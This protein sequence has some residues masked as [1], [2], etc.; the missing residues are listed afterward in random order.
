MLHLNIM[1]HLNTTLH[2]SIM[3]HRSITLRRSIMP[4]RSITLRHHVQ[5]ERYA[6]RFIIILDKVVAHAQKVVIG[7][8][9]TT[10]L[11]IV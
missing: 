4:H 2:R 3:P 9:D 11:V 6:E 1:L 10:L 8:K 5:L 7:F